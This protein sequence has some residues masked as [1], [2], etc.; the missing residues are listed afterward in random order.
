MS[1]DNKVKAGNTL[2]T[3]EWQTGKATHRTLILRVERTDGLNGA[4]PS[5]GG[6]FAGA[7]LAEGNV[8]LSAAG[9]VSTE[10]GLN[11]EVRLQLAFCRKKDSAP[12]PLLRCLDLV[13]VLR[14]VRILYHLSVSLN[15]LRFRFD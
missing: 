7:L 12:S 9:L 6:L 14:L 15:K 4:S 10:T 3:R 2:S 1:R 13:N 8:R 5:P 11:R